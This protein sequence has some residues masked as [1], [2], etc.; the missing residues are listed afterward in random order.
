MQKTLTINK[1]RFT[2]KQIAQKFDSQNMTV[3]GSYILSLNNHP[4]FGEYRQV[5][6]EYFAPVCSE[7]NANA[8]AIMPE[9]QFYH[10][11]WMEL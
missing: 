7:N 9:G 10:Y 2:A 5:Q 8:I 1:K 4:Y 3:G 11:I 6:D